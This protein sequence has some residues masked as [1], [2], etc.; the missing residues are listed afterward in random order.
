MNFILRF[1]LQ[2]PLFT[3]LIS[4]IQE[5]FG[6]TEWWITLPIGFVIIL[7]YDYAEFMRYKEKNDD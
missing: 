7:L 3:I 1:L 5:V 4:G 6:R 2:V